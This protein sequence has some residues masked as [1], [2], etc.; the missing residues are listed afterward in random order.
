MEDSTCVP[1]W[2]V[3][4]AAVPLRVGRGNFVDGGRRQLPDRVHLVGSVDLWLAGRT[5]RCATSAHLGARCP[6][7]FSDF[8]CRGNVTVDLTVI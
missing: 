3:E 4:I 5:R 2:A 8:S 6:T 7:R 1:T